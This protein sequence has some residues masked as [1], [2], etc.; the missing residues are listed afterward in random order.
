VI[1]DEGCVTGP[2]IFSMDGRWIY[3][4]VGEAGEVTRIVRYSVVDALRRFD[5]TP[6]Y[7]LVHRMKPASGPG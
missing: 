4:L 7:E 3:A 1:V 5:E 6:P 2:P